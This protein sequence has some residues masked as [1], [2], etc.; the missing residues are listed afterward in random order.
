MLL[1]FGPLLLLLSLTIYCI[2][3]LFDMSI[4][5]LLT[6]QITVTKDR[7]WCTC[8]DFVQHRL[9]CKHILA[10]AD[11][12][13]FNL[14]TAYHEAAEFNASVQ[15]TGQYCPSVVEITQQMKEPEEGK[16][17]P[18]DQQGRSELHNDDIDIVD[19]CQPGPSTNI[20]ESIMPLRLEVNIIIRFR[21]GAT[22]SCSKLIWLIDFFYWELGFT[23]P[24]N[25]Y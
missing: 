22:C 6:C 11:N 12:K 2:I 23:T 15:M 17:V 19:D 18:I 16:E 1:L 9:P 24:V 21:L 10:V 3:K 13:L 25:V 20:E 7:V 14:P 4:C 8:P 5:L